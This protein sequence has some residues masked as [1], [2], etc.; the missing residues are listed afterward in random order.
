[1]NIE[2]AKMV[3]L[4]DSFPLRYS[5]FKFEKFDPAQF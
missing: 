3:L 4:K 2:Q 1:M 5:N